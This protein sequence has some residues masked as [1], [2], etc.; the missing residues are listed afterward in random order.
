VVL[1]AGLWIFFLRRAVR[2]RT[3]ELQAALNRAEDASKL[4]SS[5]VANMSHEIRTPLNAIIGF[6]DL[7]L[8][9]ARGEQRR[10]LDTIRVSANT[11]LA[12][13]NDVLD[14]SK[15]ESGKLD[16]SPEP[17][18]PHEVIEEALDL[19]APAAAQK[20]LE[21]GYLIEP[22]VP[23]RVSLDGSRLRQVLMNLLSNA[24]KFTDRGTVSLVLSATPEDGGHAR[25]DFAVRDT[26]IGID[27][28]QISKLF[29]P[30]QQLD[31][32]VRRKHGG[33]GLGLTIS[34]HLVRLMGGD[35]YVGSTPGK[36][37]TF[38]ASLRCKVLDPP[39]KMGVLAK[40]AAVSLLIGLPF[41]R[42][43][44][45]SLLEQA[46]IPVVPLGEAAMIVADRPPSID[47]ASEHWIELTPGF[48][49]R[50]AV[51][52]GHRFV[53]LPLKREAFWKACLQ[54]RTETAPARR[55]EADK[56]LRI[57]V[58]DDNLVNLR[59][60]TSLLKRLGYQSDT[61]VN[62]LEVLASLSRQDYDIVFLDVQM[63]EMDGLEAAKRIRA[64]SSWSEKPWLVALT[65]NAMS[66]DRE[67]CLQ[68]GMNDHVAK[69]IGLK[70][71]EEAIA[72]ARVVLGEPVETSDRVPEDVGLSGE[73]M[74]LASAVS[75]CATG[76][77]VIEPTN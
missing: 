56:D 16:I 9:E 53:P 31:S 77:H 3:R 65:A 19:M 18:A 46:G 26:G 54:E 29:Q 74:R 37:T 63:P 7:L 71:V 55:P 45:E 40:P 59:V 20:G 38:T 30:F 39:A 36:G 5:F 11:L 8:D 47:I 43:I 13:I 68:A 12:V 62:G 42:Q 61:A 41:T 76:A 75:H 51:R 27:G 64:N 52:P 22:G 44:V 34:R 14:L 66:S 4:K 35:L 25:L 58:A 1:A 23:E 69:P 49:N 10:V 17:A 57:L 33:T 60:A 15:I 67:Q 48:G 24:V 50:T 72:R 28:E 6:S 2:Q 32:S 21:L 70:Q 73:L